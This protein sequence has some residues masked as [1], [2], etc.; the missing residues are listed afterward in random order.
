MTRVFSGVQP[1]GILHL[2]NYLG[3]MKK[4]E[5]LQNDFECFFAIADLH[6]ITIH[7]EPT[8]LKKRIRELACF[9]LAIGVDYNKSNIFIQ[10]HVP[11]HAQLAWLLQCN[12]Y[13]GEM[14]RMTQFKEK[15]EGRDTSTIGLL[16]YPSL[17][18]ADILLYKT[19]LV[20][21]GE[22]QKQ[23][24]EL[25]RDIAKRFNNNFGDLFV[26]PEPLINERGSRIMALD[27]PT[28][29]MSKSAVSEYNYISLLDD[30]DVIY[31]KIMRSVTDSENIIRFD[32]EKKSGISNL[33]TIVSLLT[34]T[35]I[36]SLVK[37]YENVSY[38]SFKKDV[39]EIIDFSLNTIKERF[40][41]W[42]EKK[43]L[44][45]I[46]NTGAEKAHSVAKETLQSAKE[47]MGL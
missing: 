11:E 1:T 35:K 42:N 32:A 12:V 18:A 39:A 6:A 47:L 22:D 25:T 44:D 46:M 31:K 10:S 40:Y 15:G 37:K 9:F 19:D 34:D 41:H 29:K 33:L 13:T 30:Q 23:H 14:F 3:A 21:V 43:E 2:G 8:E 26:I 24:L 4:F 7:R 45:D 17:M 20:P 36:E 38:G 16:T 5:T 28:K 27:E